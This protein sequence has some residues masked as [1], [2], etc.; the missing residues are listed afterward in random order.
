MKLV[1]TGAT[2]FIG[3]VLVDQ[4][5]YQHHSLRLLSRK[6]PRQMDISNKEWVAWKPGAGGDWEQ[7]VDGAD[8]IVNLAGEPIAGKRWS[9]AQ[10]QEL[11]GSRINATRSLVNAIARAT[12]KP[13]FLISS[14][15]VGYYGPHG[16]EILTEES[17]PGS[18]FLSRLCVEW[19]DEA[20]KA[21]AHGVRVALVRTGI[22]L[23]KGKGALAKMVPPFKRF[24]GGP[25]GSGKQWMPWI[26]IDDQIGMLNFLMEEDNARGAFNATAPNPVTMGEFSKALGEALKRPS[27]AS[28]PAAVLS[29][30]LGEMA[31]M[32]LTGQR[33]LPQA[34]LD[35]GYKFKFQRVRD[36]LESLAL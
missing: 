31:D 15:A 33:A 7:V 36:A 23:G 10:K 20:R 34:A 21:E 16:D 24:M 35:L 12:A 28:I 17:G 9:V 6:P 29:L 1:I 4:L 30:L 13:K 14:S 5:L 27:W 22:V 19:E 18:D 3:S 25:L 2:G 26:H 11:R 32:L 8:G